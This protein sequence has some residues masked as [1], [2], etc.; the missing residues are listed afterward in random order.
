MTGTGQGS[1]DGLRPPDMMDRGTRDA[2][3][4]PE[5]QRGAEH[6]DR[7]GRRGPGPGLDPPVGVGHRDRAVGRAEID[8]DGAHE[9]S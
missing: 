8:S 9:G 1:L 4:A 3:F 7:S 6:A 2:A 5:G